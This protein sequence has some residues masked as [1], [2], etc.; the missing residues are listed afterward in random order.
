RNGSRSENSYSTPHQQ[1]NFA[2]NLFATA[3]NERWTNKRTWPDTGEFK[4]TVFHS[5]PLIEAILL[6]FDRPKMNLNGFVLKHV[7]T[8]KNSISA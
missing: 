6:H 2:H 5:N 1:E 4:R 7:G 8:I 3:Y